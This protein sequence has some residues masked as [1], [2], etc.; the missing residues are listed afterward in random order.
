MSKLGDGESQ[1]ALEAESRT[2]STHK[3]A[4]LNAEIKFTEGA[5]KACKDIK[6]RR[7]FRYHIV[8][9]SDSSCSDTSV[10]L[11]TAMSC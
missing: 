2:K 9:L 6:F 8:I 3:M 5:S 10:C 1:F 7:K 4:A 11:I